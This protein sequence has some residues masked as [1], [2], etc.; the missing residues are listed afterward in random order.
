MGQRLSVEPA[1]VDRRELPN[2]REDGRIRQTHG[3]AAKMAV[4]C[5]TLLE[6]TKYIEASHAVHTRFATVA[7]RIFGSVE[8]MFERAVIDLDQVSAVMPQPTRRIAARERPP[9]NVEALLDNGPIGQNQ[10]GHGCL[11]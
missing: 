10:H 7:I 2:E 3:V 4:G 6:R 1:A 11:R 5:Q 9:H 8:M